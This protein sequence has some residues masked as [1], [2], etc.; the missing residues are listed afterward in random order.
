MRKLSLLATAVSI[1][2][3]SS[4]SPPA[5]VSPAGGPAVVAAAFMQAVADSNL[6]QMGALWGTERGPAATTKQPSDW[7][8]RITV[9]QAY[10][11]GG[12]S[13]VVSE[14]DPAMSAEGRRQVMVE[15]DRGNCLKQVPFTMVL[16]RDGA[17]LVNA[18]DLPAAGVPGRSCPPSGT[19]PPDDYF[20]Q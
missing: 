14:A 20:I 15:I 2:A 8:Q 19:R 13:R 10:L 17:W 1:A 11:R 9:I 7:I 5:Q 16:T 3:C 6:A 12:R 18:I 4:S